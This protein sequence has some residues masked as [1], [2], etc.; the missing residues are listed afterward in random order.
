V[1]GGITG[2]MD[3]NDSFLCALNKE[4]K[5]ELNNLYEAILTMETPEELH[6]FFADLCSVN[7]LKAMLHRWQI[8][9]RI[10][11]G[12]SYEEII[13]R[14][15][16]AEGVSKSTVSSTTIS[17]VK[18]CYVNEDGGYRTALNRLRNKNL[19]I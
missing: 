6:S 18:N 7:E 5:E 15:T 13:K 1:N 12:M 2:I 17:R 3:H 4:E 16:P 10:D 8:V 11:K 9:L 14:L 19:D